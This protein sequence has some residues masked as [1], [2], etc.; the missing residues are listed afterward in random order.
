[1]ARERKSPQEKKLREYS[2]RV[3]PG[4]RRHAE[5][6]KKEK[7]N[8]GRETRSKRD[9]LLSQIKPQISSEDAEV[10]AGELTTTHLQKSV[11]RKRA[12][13]YSAEPLS[14]VIEWQQERRRD[15]FGRRTKAHPLYEKWAKESVETL[16]S[17]KGG[18]FVDVARC[19]GRLCSPEYRYK[20][21]SE[22]KPED[23]IDRA[24]HFLCRVATH[25]NEENQAL[26]R[27][28]DLDKMI[29]VWIQKANRVLAKDRLAA[30]KKIDAQ[31]V[32][33]SKSRTSEK[34]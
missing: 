31:K 18:R 10:I 14:R 26:C 8:V 27:N 19:A 30:Q 24:L 5:A 28:K 16:N 7:K 22:L 11:T 25:S 21:S 17:I 32:V 1:M 29:T 6:R 20:F 12:L 13:K 15:S 9:E 3:T 33:K 4:N 34:M 2:D 23:P